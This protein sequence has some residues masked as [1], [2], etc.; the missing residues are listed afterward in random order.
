MSTDSISSAY[1]LYDIM[2]FESDGITGSQLEHT[3]EGSH[4]EHACTHQHTGADTSQMTPFLPTGAGTAKSVS[5]VCS[6]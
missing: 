1:V 5:T 3:H 4:V 6:W 2:T